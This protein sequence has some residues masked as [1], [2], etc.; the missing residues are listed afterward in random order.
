MKKRILCF[1]DSNTYGYVPGGS[2]RRYS[3]EIRWPARLQ[4][5]LGNEYIVIEDG[6]PGRT[7]DIDAPDEPWKNG[8]AY[9]RGVL[10]T[11]RPID[12]VIIMLGTND[13]KAELHRESSDIADALRNIVTTAGSFL[14]EKQNYAPKTMIIAPAC[15]NDRIGV[16]YDFGFDVYSIT[17]SRE[18]AEKYRTA[19]S[20]TDALFLDASQYVRTSP[21]DGVHLTPEAH[22]V[23]ADEVFRTVSAWFSAHPDL[24]PN[25]IEFIA[26]SE[27]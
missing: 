5:L 6:L 13:L 7:T 25:H 15:L 22:A 18:L 24:D 9:L 27:S 10:S 2:G 1:G 21:V 8:M 12:M 26:G 19:A 16:N 17:K 11:H 23:L 14:K 3:E 20:E 4:M